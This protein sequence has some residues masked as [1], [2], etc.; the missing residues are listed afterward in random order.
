METRFYLFIHLCRSLSICYERAQ[1]YVIQLTSK[2]IF[3]HSLPEENM[4]AYQA[5]RDPMYLNY[6]PGELRVLANWLS[7]RLKP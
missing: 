1:K 4:W 3:V 6:Y 7:I 2:S 5:T